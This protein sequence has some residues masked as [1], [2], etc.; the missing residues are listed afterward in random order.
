MS[1]LVAF[2]LQAIGRCAC[3]GHARDAGSAIALARPSGLNRALA[4]HPLSD[5]LARPA[6]GLGLLA[7]AFL[8]R[9]F[10]ELPALHFPEGALALH[11]LL[12]RP[13]GLFDIVVADDDLN[14]RNPPFSNKNAASRPRNADP[15]Y[16]TQLSQALAD[17][18]ARRLSAQR[19]IARGALRVH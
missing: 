10:V 12:Q 3:E 9:F 16:A 8:G 13:K 1:G 14:Q 15:R 7:G 17:G 18:A 6:H 5:Q 11:F 4:L 19:P 2:W